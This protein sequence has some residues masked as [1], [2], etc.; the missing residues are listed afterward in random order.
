[1]HVIWNWALFSAL[2]PVCAGVCIELWRQGRGDHSS[3][4]VGL[5][6]MFAL[7]FLSAVCWG[8]I[9]TVKLKGHSA[10]KKRKKIQQKKSQV[11]FSCLR[12]LWSK[13]TRDSGGRK[14]PCYSQHVQIFLKNTFWNQWNVRTSS[15]SKIY[16]I[17]ILQS[18]WKWKVFLLSVSADP[19]EYQWSDTLSKTVFHKVAMLRVA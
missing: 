4:I 18:G 14:H 13:C 12:I 16:L 1:M 2:V 8:A 19:M 9:A 10:Q 11:G 15:C 17:H 7:I 5:L 6:V 3:Y